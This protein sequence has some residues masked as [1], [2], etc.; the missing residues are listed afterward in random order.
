MNPGIVKAGNSVQ[1]APVSTEAQD[2]LS[3][4]LGELDEIGRRDI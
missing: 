2:A 3:G 4:L 1:T